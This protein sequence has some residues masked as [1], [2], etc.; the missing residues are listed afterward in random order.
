MAVPC[1]PLP[2]RASS[3]DVAIMRRAPFGLSSALSFSALGALILQVVD[4]FT[5]RSLDA[6]AHA[7]QE[8]CAVAASARLTRNSGHSNRSASYRP[9][10][11]FESVSK[12]AFPDDVR[13]L[14]LLGLNTKVAQPRVGRQFRRL[15]V[16]HQGARFIDS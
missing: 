4:V 1:S 13:H 3:R 2:Q 10:A 7:H 9:V 11:D 5:Q 6:F 8:R 15:I 12:A 16:C 14:P